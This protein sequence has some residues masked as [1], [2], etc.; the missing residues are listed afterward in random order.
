MLIDLFRTLLALVATL[1]LFGL[2][3]YAARRWG[4]KGLL[5]LS[6]ATA[7]RMHVVESISLDPTRRL[8]MVAIDGEE[9]LILLGDAKD[10]GAPPRSPAPAVDPVVTS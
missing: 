7:R 8:V 4:P 5:R 2:A 3:V 1:G 9:R 10:L 6:V